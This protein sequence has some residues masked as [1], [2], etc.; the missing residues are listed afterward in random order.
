MRAGQIEWWVLGLCRWGG[1]GGVLG[2]WVWVVVS[3]MVHEG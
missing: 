3:C 2:A 1:G